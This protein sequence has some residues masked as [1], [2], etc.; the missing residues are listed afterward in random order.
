[1]S[2]FAGVQRPISITF[3][4]EKVTEKSPFRK[5][6]FSLQ[7]FLNNDQQV[8]FIH[9]EKSCTCAVESEADLACAVD[10]YEKVAQTPFLSTRVKKICQRAALDRKGDFSAEKESFQPGL[11]IA[12]I[13]KVNLLKPFG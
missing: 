13:E 10:L 8:P 5:A 2:E 9:D 6:G 11:F 1:V 12:S 4:T 3:L 7:M